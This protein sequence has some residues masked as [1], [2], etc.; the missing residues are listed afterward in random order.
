MIIETTLQ[1]FQKIIQIKFY[2]NIFPR[3]IELQFILN[4]YFKTVLSNLLII[5]Q[6]ILIFI[7]MIEFI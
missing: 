4:I 1:L 7:Y 6:K 3:V 2:S 5:V